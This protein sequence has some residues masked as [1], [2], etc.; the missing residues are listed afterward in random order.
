[1]K[2]KLRKAGLLITAA[3][4]ILSLSGCIEYREEIS[5]NKDG[6]G[7]LAFDLGLPQH[8]SI[9]EEE[10]NELSIVSLCDS[11]EGVQVINSS[12]YEV[13]EITWIHVDAEFDDVVLLNDIRNE[14]FGK[15]YLK[16]DDKGDY[17]F[18]RMISMSD[19]V[20]TD[21]SK[22]GR[23]LKYAF[24]GQYSWIYTVHFPTELL[25]SN[26]PLMRTDT[27]SNT[28]TWE[29]NLASLINEEKVMRARYRRPKGIGYFFR[30]LF[31]R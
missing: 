29:Y 31:A 12:T 22:F 8:T 7:T 5:L 28:V 30:N 23:T 6:S 2:A 18:E 16:E 10:I 3:V 1:M 21:F 9:D 24:L 4:W 13:D 15:I 14:W 17:V 19:T 26:A 27:L 11:V 25:G 20:S